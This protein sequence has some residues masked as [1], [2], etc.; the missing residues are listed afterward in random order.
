MSEGDQTKGD[1]LLEESELGVEL[2]TLVER[3]ILPQR[4]AQRIGEKLKEKNLKITKNQLYKLSEKIQNTLRSYTS[5]PQSQMYQDKKPETQAQIKETTEPGNDTIVSTTDMKTLVDAVEKLSE[6]IKIIEE[7][8]IEG[9]KGVT[10]KLVR[11]KD[12]KTLSPTDILDEDLQRLE[13]IPTDPESIVIIMKWLQYLVEK[14]GKNHLPNILGY[15]VDIGWISDDVRLDLLDY[16]KGITDIPN[17]TNPPSSH[18]PT[19]DHVQSLLFIQK[20]KGVQLDDRFLNKI[21]R[22]MEKILKSLEAYQLK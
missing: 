10:G 21:E 3:N 7:K 12:V 18:L 9:V 2:T 20:L 14:L 1:K 8:Q 4:I 6:R 16:S 22:D 5:S 19:R 11:T 13:H 17:Q 15:Y